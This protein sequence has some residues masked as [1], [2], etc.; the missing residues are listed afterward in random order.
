MKKLFFTIALLF[1]TFAHAEV[2]PKIDLVVKTGSS[3]NSVYSK[4]FA[5]MTEV[6]KS[7]V[8]LESPAAGS[9]QALDGLLNNEASLAFVQSDVV[10]GR[11]MIE[12]D[13]MVDNV[14]IFMPL[15]NSELH[16][17]ASSS[18]PNINR[19][20]D[21]FQK[22]VG[23]YGGGYIT[24]RIL[25]GA[26]NIRPFSLTQFDN[27]AGALQ[28]LKA[29]QVDAIMIVAG[30]PAS[31]AKD[32]TSA[33]Y[34]LVPFDRMDVLGKLGSYSQTNL[35]Y[36]N[37]SQTTVPSVA[38]QINLVTYNY[39]SAEKIKNLAK[40]KACIASHIDELRETT[41]N[42]PKWNEI[43]PNAKVSYWP[44]FTGGK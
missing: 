29:G 32:L 35:R 34:K 43:K 15:F 37:L 30:Q 9:I 24:S 41:G 14:R 11:K 6:C 36:P 2:A 10:L 12:N 1:A 28:A 22:K 23:A 31:W 7:P 17:V 19:F 39:K 38:V 16:I 8:L 42:H 33:T 27:E 4:L 13:P 3:S 26:A 21:L 44:M 20:S 5:Q 40:L 25:F 18:N